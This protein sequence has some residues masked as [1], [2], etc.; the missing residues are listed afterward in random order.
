[1]RVPSGESI[2]RVVLTSPRLVVRSSG[3]P[4]KPRS[5]TMLAGMA[6]SLEVGAFTP[7]IKNLEMA[8]LFRVLHRKTAGGFVPTESLVPPSGTFHSNLSKFMS[9]MKLSLENAVPML[10]EDFVSEQVGRKKCVY[11]RALDEFRR[12]GFMPSQAY[13]NVFIKYEKDIRELKPDRVPRAISPAGFVYLLLTG[14]YVKAVE[15]LVYK[16]IDL[17]YGHRTVAKGTNYEQMADMTMDAYDDIS[18]AVVLDLDVEKLDASVCVEGLQI[19]HEIVG[20]C[21]HG[22]DRRD[23]ESLLQLQLYPNVRG[24]TKDGEL[25]YKMVGTLTS[26][27]MNTALVGILL[28]CAILHEPIKKYRA[29][30]I[31]M[32]DDCRIIVS[33]ANQKAFIRAV[34][35]RFATFGMLITLEVHTDIRQ[36]KFCQTQLI[37]VGGQWT[38]MRLPHEA[39]TKDLVCIKNYQGNHKLAGWLK[40]VGIG[41]MASHGGIPV[42]QNF[43]RACIRIA[44]V[45]L[46]SKKLSKRQERSVRK[47]V[48]DALIEKKVMWAASEHRK[49]FLTPSDD[50]R[51]DFFIATGMTPGNQK[52]AELFFDNME[53]NWNYGLVPFFNNLSYLF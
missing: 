9:L 13:I 37:R 8:V 41:G 4:C 39:I 32:G 47:Q 11:Q 50:T 18:D 7:S 20:H 46:G 14:V 31:N 27:Q 2:Q 16:A 24:Y 30:L 17:V 28:V 34:H 15:K 21:F 40:S 44:E 23:I 12:V 36:S 25:K 45:Q 26:G 29:R 49:V 5:F 35:E 33:G 3:A 48:S 53:M 52:E 1:V 10:H 42:L 6:T 19:T 51:F 38:A 22:D 43:Y